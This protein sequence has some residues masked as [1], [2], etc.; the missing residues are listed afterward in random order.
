MKAPVRSDI[1]SWTNHI[2][3]HYRVSMAEPWIFTSLLYTG[4]SSTVGPMSVY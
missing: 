3:T 4:Y 1:R 2:K